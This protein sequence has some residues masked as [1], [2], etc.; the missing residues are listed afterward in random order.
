MNQVFAVPERE[1]QEHPVPTPFQLLLTASVSTNA[2]EVVACSKYY[3][4]QSFTCALIW[5]FLMQLLQLQSAAELCWHWAGPSFPK[6]C[7]R[8]S[9]APAFRMIQRHCKTQVSNHP[10]P[11]IWCPS[12]LWAYLAG[13][14]I[15]IHLY[16]YL[17][18]CCPETHAKLTWDTWAKSAV[19]A[20]K[21]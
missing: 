17:K 7:S 15:L 2:D 4:A 5:V 3:M 9:N 1:A 6:R 11:L 19:A 16:R 21:E 18:C 8:R 10:K 12:F 20:G 13:L 14:C